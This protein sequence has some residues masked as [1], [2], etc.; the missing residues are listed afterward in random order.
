MRNTT[1][2]PPD[3]T[4]LYNSLAAQLAGPVEVETPQLGRVMFPRPSELYAAL[5]YL[6]LAQAAMNGTATTGVF[7]VQYDSGLWP[8]KGGCC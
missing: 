4:A 2:P 8:P 1:P 5:N 7:V 6:R 3:W